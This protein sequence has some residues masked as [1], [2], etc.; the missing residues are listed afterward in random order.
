VSDE[1][2]LRVMLGLSAADLEALVHTEKMNLD[3]RVRERATSLLLLAQ[4]KTCAQVAKLQ[5]LSMRTL[6]NTRKRWIA[7]GLSGLAE[8]PRSGAPAKVSTPEAERLLQW[9]RDEP[10]TRPRS[11]HAMQRRAAPR[12]I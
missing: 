12:C 8:R 1:M 6:S 10:L 7:A 2:P 5:E 11:K 3:W 9:A 4:G